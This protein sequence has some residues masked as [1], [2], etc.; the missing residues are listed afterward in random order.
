MSGNSLNTRASDWIE[1][2]TGAGT[3]NATALTASSAKAPTATKPATSEANG[4]YVVD[5]RDGPAGKGRTDWAMHYALAFLVQ[6]ADGETFGYRVW[7]WV[8]RG[9]TW[10]PRLLLA[11]T[12]A[13]GA[14]VGGADAD[15]VS[16]QW[17]LADTITN[18]T[19][20]TRSAS[21]QVD[22]DTDGLAELS[23]DASGTALLEVEISIDASTAAKVRPMLRA[24]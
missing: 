15:G 10:V 3:A 5:L 22:A 17:F 9:D 14:R 4:R 6:D 24:L 11:G 8:P 12:G 23:F 7:Q 1:P 19:D 21:A 20:N 18:A 13:A 2:G 16:N